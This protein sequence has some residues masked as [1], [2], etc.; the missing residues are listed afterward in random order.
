MSIKQKHQHNFIQQISFHD[1]ILFQKLKLSADC[2]NQTET[3]STQFHSTILYY[4]ISEIEID[5]VRIFIIDKKRRYT[6][7]EIWTG[8]RHAEIEIQQSEDSAYC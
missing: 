3:S 6:S 7:G 4:S 5:C 2:V 1:T 8:F